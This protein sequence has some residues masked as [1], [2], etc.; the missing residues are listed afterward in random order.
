MKICFIIL[1]IM[2]GQLSFAQVQ[3]Q[4][5]YKTAR[6]NF[7]VQK[8]QAV[9]NQLKPGKVKYTIRI[10]KAVNGKKEGFSISAAK[11]FFQLKVMMNREFYMVVW[12]LQTGLKLL[13]H[14][15]KI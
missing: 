7:A 11:T 6:T 9:I 4:N 10:D 1:F 2:F 8:L 14:F 3:I 13:N 15:L 5:N 12:N